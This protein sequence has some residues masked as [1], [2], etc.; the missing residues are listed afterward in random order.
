MSDPHAHLT[1]VIAALPR[2]YSVR[3]ADPARDLEALAELVNA[4]AENVGE[5][6]RYSADDM[7]EHLD[8]VEPANDTIVVNDA[9]GSIVAWGSAYRVTDDPSKPRVFLMGAVHPQQR[10]QGIGRALFTWTHARAEE[11]LAAHHN[12]TIQ[13]QC[14]DTDE[15]TQHL[16][17][18][19]GMRPIRWYTSMQLHFSRRPTSRDLATTTIPA[20]Y[21]ARAFHEVDAEVLRRLRNDCFSDHWGASEMGGEAWA[22]LLGS[23]GFR[24]NDSEILVTDEGTPV[25]YQLTF[26]YPQD[27]ATIGHTQW[28]GNLGVQRQHRGRG[29]ATLLIERHLIRARARDYEGSMIDVDADSLTGANKLYERIGYARRFG[30][31]RYILGDA[32][33]S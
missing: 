21:H 16:Y 9:A 2:G 31:V 11:I 29:L 3:H 4:V 22:Q 19:F 18:R 33:F 28:V 17:A 7:R 20:G 12:G 30:E 32:S 6:I 24:P 8:A 13:A 26:E 15:R 27:S 14:T 5:P 10:A 1:T 23:S 25:A